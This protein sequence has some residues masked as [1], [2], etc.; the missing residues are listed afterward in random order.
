MV[1]S[2]K[3][4][5]NTGGAHGVTEALRR[6]K[7]AVHL[8][9]TAEVTVPSRHIH[10]DNVAALCILRLIAA[11]TGGKQKVGRGNVEGN[12][13]GYVAR[14]TDSLAACTEPRNL[15]RRKTR[16]PAQGGIC[17]AAA[18]V[19]IHHVQN[20]AQPS[21]YRYT[22]RVVAVSGHISPAEQAVF[23]ALQQVAL[24]RHAAGALVVMITE[25][26]CP[27]NAQSIHERA[28]L[29]KTPSAVIKFAVHDITRYENKIRVRLR[30]QTADVPI[31][32]GVRIFRR[33]ANDFLFIQPPAV[34]LLGCIDYLHICQLQDARRA[35]CRQPYKIITPRRGGVGGI[36][37]ICHS[38]YPFW[39]YT[40]TTAEREVQ[41]AYCRKNT[42]LFTS[43]TR[44]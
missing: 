19:G 8:P 36:T 25:H 24:P 20:T 35:S 29:L 15:I 6:G 3:Y 23:P 42:F 38:Y 31:A 40:G 10:P 2:H 33:P 27:R 34:A 28:E 7:R 16:S 26:R 9:T 30:N 41:G 39:Q 14:L 22:N 13:P 43:G 5:V 18:T 17:P 37:L 44:L 21:A 4:A 12:S 1:V 32:F 11:G